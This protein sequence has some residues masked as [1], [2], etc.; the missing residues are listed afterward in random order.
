M[1][2]LGVRTPAAAEPPAVTIFSAVLY[3]TQCV[4]VLG[5]LFAHALFVQL[6]VPV[7]AFCLLL[8]LFHF[9]SVYHDLGRLTKF[10]LAFAPFIQFVILFRLLL[11]LPAIPMWPTIV[12]CS[13]LVIICEILKDKTSSVLSRRYVFAF[14]VC[15]ILLELVR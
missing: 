10:A 2:K 9:A 15:P 6:L 3:M 13:L 11:G 4:E 5:L 1:I 14:Y 7:T 8:T 12:I